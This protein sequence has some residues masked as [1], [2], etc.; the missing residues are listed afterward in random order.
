VIMF[1]DPRT[2][3]IGVACCIKG[4]AVLDFP[5]TCRAHPS[6][7][8]HIQKST[9]APEQIPLLSIGTFKFPFIVQWDV[10]QR[11]VVPLFVE[12]FESNPN[13]LFSDLV[14]TLEADFKGKLI[15]LGYL[16]LEG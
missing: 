11:V 16:P 4:W 9:A 8:V 14:S 7:K 15:Q 12:G 3:A 5:G 6:Y 13:M 1:I 10:W 2:L